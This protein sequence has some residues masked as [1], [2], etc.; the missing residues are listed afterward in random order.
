MDPFSKRDAFLAYFVTTNPFHGMD[1]EYTRIGSNRARNR[2][3][4][5]SHWVI[6]PV[7]SAALRVVFVCVSRALKLHVRRM[8]GRKIVK[9][10]T[11]VAAV[12]VTGGGVVI[13]S[14]A[15]PNH[16]FQ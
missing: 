4:R 3:E 12:A 13:S 9:K 8:R 6:L 15:T 14:K 16:C 2:S 7:D 1:Q 10:N 5:D 11:S